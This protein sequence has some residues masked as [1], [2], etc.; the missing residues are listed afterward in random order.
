MLV[1]QME[2]T[3]PPVRLSYYRL[4]PIQ[5]PNSAAIPLAG[6]ADGDGTLATV[7]FTVVEAQASA[8]GLEAVISD[9]T[10]TRIDVTVQGGTVTGPC[11]PT[12]NGYTR[13]RRYHYK[14]RWDSCPKDWT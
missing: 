10:A 4:S 11:C 14:Y 9:P 12:G 7:T 2:I 1:L 8:I 3:Y 5:V 13:G 6:T